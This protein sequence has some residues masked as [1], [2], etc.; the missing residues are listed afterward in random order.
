MLFPY[1]TDAHD[2]IVR[3][4]APSIMALCVI[5]QIFISQDNKRIDNETNT[6]GA[7]IKKQFYQAPSPAPDSA[8]I[9]SYQL[10]LIKRS[11][12]THRANRIGSRNNFANNEERKRLY[13]K[14]DSMA[15][16][17]DSAAKKTFARTFQRGLMERA[18]E[19]FTNEQW[20]AIVDSLEID[21]KEEL[22]EKKTRIK[23]SPLILKLAFIP[24]NFNIVKLFTAMFTHADWI[25]LIGNMLF[26]YVCAI[27]LERFWGGG[28]FLFL[29]LLF[30][31]FSSLSNMAWDAA[32]G[33]S[34]NVPLVGASGAIAGL[35]GAFWVTHGKTRV[36]CVFLIFLW[37]R[38]IKL[39]AWFFM[40]FWF[41]EQAMYMFLFAHI[42]AGVAFCAHVSG[43]IAGVLAGF[44]V[45][46]ETQAAVVKAPA[47]TLRR[48]C[49]PIPNDRTSQ[50]NDTTGG[51]AFTNTLNQTSIRQPIEM[52]WVAFEHKAYDDAAQRLVA[53]ISSLVSSPHPDLNAIHGHVQRVIKEW[54]ALPIHSN[55]YYEWANVLIRLDDRFLSLQ[56]FDLAAYKSQNA[57]IKTNSLFQ[58]AKLRIELGIQPEKARKDLLYLLTLST[59]SPAASEA[60]S[61][62]DR[63]RLTPHVQ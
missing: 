37:P 21:N 17:A 44:F 3:L 32:F 53:A 47:R 6:L 11:V 26:F 4:I 12:D 16:A 25:H 41:F 51:N 54:K 30:G 63:L 36:H 55:Q 61:L 28:K 57:H 23:N 24:S 9:K 48:A 46:S 42:H 18:A 35:M 1:K 29:Y 15:L 20:Y 58:A 5:I 13:D 8:L 43:F 45:K 39:P 2:G 33:K 60:K 14:I 38:F 22:I 59:Q 19:S 62:L 27:T 7:E 56:C 31:I 40:L 10:K 49:M 34:L 50:I 52:G